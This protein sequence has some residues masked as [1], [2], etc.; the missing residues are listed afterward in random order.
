MPDRARR[1]C[2]EC[3]EYATVGAYCAKHAPPVGWQRMRDEER[4]DDE[5]RYRRWYSTASWKRMRA[6]HLASE[7]WCRACA[8]R[9]ILTPATE[10]DHIEAHR[11]DY[12]LFANDDNL[13]SLCHR[14]HSRKTMR[15]MAD[16]RTR[17]D[18]S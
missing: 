3:S 15:E 11:G 6:A 10:V 7:P 18:G 5:Q 9:G 12:E 14:C 8:E 1:Y 2:R 16:R 13:Q 17:G 4:S